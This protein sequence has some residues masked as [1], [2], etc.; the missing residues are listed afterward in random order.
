MCFQVK[1]AKLALAWPDL[2]LYIPV[3]RSTILLLLEQ[4]KWTELPKDI[5]CLESF[6]VQSVAA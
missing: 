6:S 4:L 5:F 3:D 2:H 1:D